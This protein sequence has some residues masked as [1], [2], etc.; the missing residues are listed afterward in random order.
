VSTVLGLA[1]VVA[2]ILINGYFVAAEFSFVAVKR[3]RLEDLADTGDRRAARAVQ[4][5]RRLSFMLSGAQLGITVTSLLVGFIAEPTLGRAI[6]PVLGWL[7]LPEGSRFGVALV[8]GLLL[9]TITQ[10]V[11]GELAPKNLAIARPEPVARALAGST[12]WFMRLARPAITLFDASANGLLRAVGIEPVE[13][14]QGG[15]SVEELDLIVEESAE[16]GGLTDQQAALLTRAIDFGTLR[17]A[18]VMV[19]WN[20]V[21]SLSADSTCEELRS[22]LHDSYSRFPVVTAEGHVVGVAH[23]KDLLHVPDDDVA[24]TTVASIARPALVVPE[25][26]GLRVVLDGL[27]D[28]TTEMAVVA[29]EY[30]APAGVVTLEDLVEELIGEIGDEYDE[31]SDE[32]AVVPH[33]DGGWIVPGEFRVDEVERATGIELPDEDGYATLAGLVLTRLQRIP[34]VGDHTDVGRTHLEVTAM[35]HWSITEIRLLVHDSDDDV[36]DP[37]AEGAR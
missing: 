25:T 3:G 16:R 14:L 1:A 9:A 27:R 36:D 37:P 22:G 17:A 29:D 6:E 19:P 30:G 28:E 32:H 34:K 10:M 12:L 24:T 26:A 31:A 18:A 20:R 8:I 11:V 4:V 13:E 7:G 23:V 2:L 5:H 15:V 33:P 21:V 35:D